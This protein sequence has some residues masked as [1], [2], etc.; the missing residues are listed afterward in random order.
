MNRAQQLLWEQ[1]LR[2]DGIVAAHPP[3][4]ITGAVQLPFL[5][6]FDRQREVVVG[7]LIAIGSAEDGSVTYR[8]EKIEQRDGNPV[9]WYHLTSANCSESGAA[10]VS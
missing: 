8:I 6:P 1:D 3:K 9:P 2:D 5:K 4:M 7:D 10:D